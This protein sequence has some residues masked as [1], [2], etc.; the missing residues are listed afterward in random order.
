MICL[1]LQGEA[2]AI[3]FENLTAV[4]RAVIVNSQ[5]MAIFFFSHVYTSREKPW[6]EK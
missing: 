2:M 6:E 4:L 3:S 5:S 1:K